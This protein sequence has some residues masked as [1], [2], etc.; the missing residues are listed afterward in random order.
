MWYDPGVGSFLFLAVSCLSDHPLIVVDEEQIP[1]H[2]ATDAGTARDQRL[3]VLV[4]LDRSGSMSGEAELLGWALPDL[5]RSLEGEAYRELDWRVAIVTMDPA[6]APMADWVEHDATNVQLQLSAQLAGLPANC[7]TD[8]CERGL[9]A[10]VMSLAYDQHRPESDLL[11]VFVSDEPGESTLGPEQYLWSVEAYKSDPYVVLHGAIVYL[12]SSPWCVSSG[13]ALTGDD[14]LAVA[15]VSVSLC[16]PADWVR[17]LEPAAEHVPT[18]NMVWE[19]SETPIGWWTI[20]VYVDAVEIDRWHYEASR[21]AVV[22]DPP[23]AAGASVVITYQVR[24]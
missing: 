19:L 18:L 6:D 5:L 9:D 8:S 14:Y 2:V 24:D 16:D 11:V 12:D 21:N 1:T 20:G 7:V 13:S 17:V 23:P 4:V 10:A 15:D 22:I 3:D